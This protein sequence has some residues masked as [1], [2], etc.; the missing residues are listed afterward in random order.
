MGQILGGHCSC[1]HSCHDILIGKGELPGTN[2][3]GICFTCKDVVGM[4]VPLYKSDSKPVRI[5]C[6]T[7]NKETAY[8]DLTDYESI[9]FPGKSKSFKLQNKIRKKL[10]DFFSNAPRSFRT[11]LYRYTQTWQKPYGIMYCPNC[12]IHRMKMFLEGEW[13]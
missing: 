13:D 4:R 3:I 11:R 1:G 2:I 9:E 7:C 10:N 5:A 6:P 8:P 12:G